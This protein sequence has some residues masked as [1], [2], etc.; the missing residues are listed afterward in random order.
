[1]VRSIWR[2]TLV[3]TLAWAGLAW[4][5]AP[6]TTT[7]P[8]TNV[9]DRVITVQENGK[10]AQKCRIVKTWQTADGATAY[11]VQAV[12][13][14]EILTIV[15]SGPTTTTD[16]IQPGMRMKAV[17]TRIFHWG[18]ES[19]PPPGTPTPPTEFVQTS[20]LPS[21]ISQPSKL[22]A[23]VA[24]TPAAKPLV[25]VVA[26]P[27]ST[28]STSAM[29]STDSITKDWRRSWGKADDQKSIAAP[30]KT[31]IVESKPVVAKTS[32][33]QADSSRP[34]PLRTPDR[35]SKMPTE[36]PAAP[37]TA[38]STEVKPAKNSFWTSRDT[39]TT[40]SVTPTTPPTTQLVYPKSE[41]TIVAK[42]VETPV[43]V[44]VSTLPPPTP[45]HV[46]APP[47]T[48][49]VIESSGVPSSIIDVP[50]PRYAP[51]PPVHRV[52]PPQ[53][54]GDRSRQ[55]VATIDPSARVI[56]ATHT[57]TNP[58]MV[59]AFTTTPPAETVANASNAFTPAE[60]VLNVP[61][62]P[63]MGYGAP[64]MAAQTGYGAPQAAPGYAVVS[65]NSGSTATPAL[66][67]GQRP[68]GQNVEQMMTVLRD[69]LYPSQRE[70]AAESM[71]SVDWRAH[72]EVV[73]ALV[74]ASR[75]DPAATVR[76]GCIRCMAK[77]NANTPSV[78]QAVQS[79][80]TDADA[81][82]RQEA[83]QALNSLTPGL[84]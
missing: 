34:D 53:P 1:M 49:T 44:P 25:Q 59:N 61:A 78:I 23:P 54:F 48:S 39:S 38:K 71:A 37:V 77:M 14:G 47:A 64:M 66:V 82:V 60:Q 50:D 6:Q 41:S 20:P 10:T 63:T 81:R 19:T 76:A 21:P 9:V 65:S 55:P 62:R 51:Q 18:R 31:E 5:Q 56:G 22:A 27:P 79:L 2:R 52:Q 83:D 24:S 32:L 7:R 74:K 84:R 45:V 67:Q 57:T 36:Y 80:K 29:P 69:S 33:P 40:K 26:P 72:P 8:A 70:W 16:G 28:P 73:T 12:D 13:T 68:T 30:A 42:P 35:Y 4:A 75:E 3:S 58:A 17:A 15:E 43:A 46:P 11:Q